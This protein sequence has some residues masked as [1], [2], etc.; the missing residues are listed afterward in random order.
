M[1]KWGIGSAI[2]YN[3][4]RRRYLSSVWTHPYG[5]HLP[6]NFVLLVRD[7][8]FPYVPVEEKVDGPRVNEDCPWLEGRIV[9]EARTCFSPNPTGSC[10][11]KKRKGS[12]ASRQSR[13]RAF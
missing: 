4:D 12:G 9:N 1:A 5:K 3:H 10:R 2:V 6:Y 8:G 7:A 13:S 11:R